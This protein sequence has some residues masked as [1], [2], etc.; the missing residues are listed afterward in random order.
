MTSAES[1]SEQPVLYGNT[2]EHLKFLSRQLINALNTKTFSDAA[3]LLMVQNF[4]G[5]HGQD[6]DNLVATS[7]AELIETIEGFLD[8]N[9]NFHSDI[10]DTSAEVDEHLGIGKV[11]ILRTDTGLAEGP[12]RET[13]MEL[14]WI[15]NGNEWFC[16]G[17]Q[18]LRS[19]PYYAS[20]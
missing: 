18:G 13:F 1:Q 9:P 19:F 5:F 3:N 14:S 10:L 11:S 17:Y 12:N 20:S 8:S 6:D 2:Q 7:R 15:R 16:N 4:S